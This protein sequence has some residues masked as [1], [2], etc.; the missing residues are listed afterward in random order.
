MN[1]LRELCCVRQQKGYL[2]TDEDD[3]YDDSVPLPELSAAEII[4]GGG[5]GSEYFVSSL[6]SGVS[7]MYRK[8]SSWSLPKQ[9]R[10]NLF[11]L[12]EDEFDFLMPSPP[13]SP[14]SP[15]SR[16]SSRSR[17]SPLS[18]VNFDDVVDEA[19]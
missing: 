17:R 6:K 13:L 12:N 19:V 8:M 9:R 15:G 3:G 5:G 7:S 18:S 4:G 16:R 11:T 10:V 2:K 14:G 1:W